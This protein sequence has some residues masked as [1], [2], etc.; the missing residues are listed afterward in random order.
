MSAP[1]FQKLAGGRRG[2]GSRP[3][4]LDSWQSGSGKNRKE[5][6]HEEPPD[7]D[8]LPIEL[9]RV[10]NANAT[11]TKQSDSLSIKS[12]SLGDILEIQRLDL[13]RSRSSIPGLCSILTS[14]LN[15]DAESRTSSSMSGSKP[16]LVKQKTHLVDDV[17]LE[18]PENTAIK[19][20]T[21]D[22]PDFQV[23]KH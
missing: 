10:E 2:S 7:V 19:E 16:R 20:L 11:L 9:R 23:G 13:V 18:N 8:E 3:W 17:G 15:L 21:K 6:E 14:E 22:V 1:L 4:F 12:K 5:Y